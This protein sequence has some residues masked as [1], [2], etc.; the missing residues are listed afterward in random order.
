[1]I[2]WTLTLGAITK[3]LAEWGISDPALSRANLA[4]DRLTFTFPRARFDD[5]DLCAQGA[6]AILTR[7]ENSTAVV[8]FRGTRQPVAYDCQAQSEAQTYLFEGPWRFLAENVYQQPWNGVYTSHII[9][10]ATV[11]QNIRAVLDYAIARGA[12]F[13]YVLADLTALA[14]YPPANEVTGQLCSSVILASLQ[15][16]PDVVSWCDYSTSPP[17]LRFS[18][19]ASLTAASVRLADYEGDDTMP[20]VNVLALRPREDLQVPSVKINYET[21]VTIDGVQSLVPGVEIAPD[22]ATGLEDGAFTDTVIRQ[23]LTQ[24]NLFASLECVTVESDSLEWWKKHVAKFREERVSVTGPISLGYRDSAGAVLEAAA[25]HL[26]ENGVFLPTVYARELPRGGGQIAPWMNGEDGEPLLWQTE[27]I[28]AAFTII[29]TDATGAKLKEETRFYTVEIVTTTAPDGISDYSAVE[30]Q[31]FGDPPITGLAAY[32][33]AALSPLQYE[34]SVS[35]EEEECTGLLDLGR[36]VNL[37]GSRAAFQTMRAV[38][39][40]V[41]FDIESGRTSVTFGPPRHLTVGDLLALMERFRISRRYTNQATQETGEI[42]GSDTGDLELGQATGS[43]NTS[44]GANEPSYL[45]VQVGANKIIMDAAA[46][47]MT[48][49]NGINTILF[50]AAL[51]QILMNSLVPGAGSIDL[52]LADTGGHAI[53]I[54]E[55]GVCVGGVNKKVRGALSPI[56]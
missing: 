32:L 46:G 35:L 29:E 5:D 26:D 38:A 54:R 34:G 11:G 6:A 40:Q 28:K 27:F 24:N 2:V 39:Q 13:T 8:W 31:D 22:G 10:N 16:A 20:V 49:T 56:Y 48:V 25:V 30:S 41:T 19:R 15:F 37:Y 9:V 23:G 43:T 45:V 7:A 4:A 50:N 33:Y 42:G 12:L 36:V 1:M 44:S 21:I 52:A 55:I 53:M 3:T 14:A 18:P 17:T 47:R 51:G